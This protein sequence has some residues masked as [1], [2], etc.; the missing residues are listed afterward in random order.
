M[1]RFM[2]ALD[3][4]PPECGQPVPAGERSEPGALHHDVPLAESIDIAFTGR[5]DGIS[6]E[7]APRSR[8]ETLRAVK[9]LPAR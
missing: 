9:R 8:L 5:P 2:A 1:A 4:A 3:I 7:A 6:F